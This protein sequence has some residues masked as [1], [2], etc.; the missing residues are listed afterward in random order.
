MQIFALNTD[1]AS[2]V[3]EKT[4]NG[5]LIWRH[6]G[7]RCDTT[8]LPNWAATRGP[9][10]YS[11]DSDAPMSPAPA[12]GLGWFGPE[13][14]VLRDSNGQRAPFLPDACDGKSTD[15]ALHFTFRDNHAAIALTIK[16]ARQPGGAFTFSSSITN[17]GNAPIEVERLA[18]AFLPISAEAASILSWRGRHNAELFEVREPMP[19]HRWEKITRRGQSGHGGAPGLYVL[20]ETTGWDDGLCLALQLCWSGNHSLSVERDD[21]GAWHLIASALPEAG[22]IIVQPGESWAAPDAILALS[23][24]GKNGAMRQ[25]HSAIRA[26]LNWPDGKMSP[27]PVHCNS[28]EAVYFSH[29]EDRIIALA[30]AAAAIGAERFV[31]D[32][33]WFAGRRGDNAGLGDWTPDPNIYPNG[34]APLAARLAALNLEFGLWVEP[35]MI[36]PDSDL[37]RRNP[38]W[39]LH[40]PGRDRLTARNQ[41][42]LNMA[43]EDVRDHLFTQLSNLLAEGTIGYLKWDHNRDLAPAGGAL[44]TAGTYALMQRLRSAFPNVEIEGCAGGGGRSDAGLVP[45]IHRFWVSDNLDAVSRVS[46]QRSFLHFMPPDILGSHVGAAPSH[47]TGRSQSLAFRAAIACMGHMG[48][49]MDPTR[50]SDRDRAQLADWLAFYK[51]WRGC[52]LGQDVVL[53]TGADGLVWQAHGGP[54]DCLLFVIRTTP[55]TDRRPQPL[56]L[57]FAAEAAHWDVELLRY[58]GPGNGTLP[59]GPEIYAGEATAHRWSGSWLAQNGLPLPTQA[60][61]SVAIFHLRQAD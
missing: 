4:P 56:R 38:D 15:D 7:A 28:W 47:A 5:G 31:L 51:Q 21:E 34:L 14:V 6:C 20:E 2:I 8:N 11:L 40:L 26:M 1:D 46:M 61:E 19:E 35:E 3:F 30:E 45:F 59:P 50:L 53:G 60:A 16:I 33:G 12:A 49:E 55:F 27:R 17:D 43:R 29:D 39:A 9:A 48:V 10:T 44:Q 36:N 23:G 13:T 57:P 37:Y 41:L 54:D 32:D 25:Q 24:S 42:V 58:A 52:T 18:S 22:E